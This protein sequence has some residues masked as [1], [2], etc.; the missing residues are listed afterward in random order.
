MQIRTQHTFFSIF[1][2]LLLFHV[3]I[4]RAYLVCLELNEL[5]LEGGPDKMVYIVK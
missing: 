3:I 2:V 4:T 5:S 1:I